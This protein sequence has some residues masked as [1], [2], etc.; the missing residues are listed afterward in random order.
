M[1]LLQMSWDACSGSLQPPCKKSG[2]PDPTKWKE[3][4]EIPEGVGDGERE[5]GKEKEREKKWKEFSHISP[6][7]K[8]QPYSYNLERMFWK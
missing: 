4:L 5:R 7:R 6:V 1:Q 3:N 8:G 2:Y